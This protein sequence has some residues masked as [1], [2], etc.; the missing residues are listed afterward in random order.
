V[1][2]K[3]A[4]LKKE[5]NM[6]AYNSI[7]SKNKLIVLIRYL[8][9]V[10]LPQR[11]KIIVYNV[12]GLSLGQMYNLEPLFDLLL[13]KSNKINSSQLYLDMISETRWLIVR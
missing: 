6:A 4:V 3:R 12:N 11:L 7:V 13:M 10:F 1:F 5:N 9:L 2:Q 8:L